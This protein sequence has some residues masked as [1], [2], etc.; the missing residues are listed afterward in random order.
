MTRRCGQARW[1]GTLACGL[2]TLVWLGNMSGCSPI[3][4]VTSVVSPV[5]AAKRQI[6]PATDDSIPLRATWS[7]HG[8]DRSIT[9]SL[10]WQDACVVRA[11]QATETTVVTTTKPNV[12]GDVA[13]LVAGL[14]LIGGG[15]TTA[16]LVAPSVGKGGDETAGAVGGA[17]I[18]AGIFGLVATYYSIAELAKESTTTRTSTGTGSHETLGTAKVSCGRKDALAGMELALEAQG[19][20]ALSAR[21][22]RLGHARFELPED[23]EVD[24][25]A[26]A[27][28]TIASSPDGLASLL[29]AGTVLGEVSLSEYAS[30]IAA[31]RA[32]SDSRLRSAIREA[33]AQDFEGVI[34]GD[35]TAKQGFSLA[36]T[37]G[38]K[39]V[40]FD[41]IDNDC[42]GLYDVGC[43]YESGALQWTLAWKTGDDLDLH[44]VGPDNVEVFYAHRKGGSSGLMLDIDC[45]GQFG[46]NCLASNVENIFTPRDKKPKEGTY[47]G[48]VEVF[49]AAS[50]DSDPGRVISAML[51]G[52]IAG[53]TFRMPMTLAAQRH[54]RVSFAFAVGKDRDKDSV[55]DRE[56]ACPGEAGVFSSYPAEN[57][58]PDRDMDGVADKLDA[59]PDEVGLR[60]RAAKDNGCPRK[61]GKAWLTDR[62]VHITEAIHF[63]S[64]SAVISAQSY[65]LLKDIGDVMRA[66]PELLQEVNIEGHTDSDGEPPKNRKLSFERVKSV[67]QHLI[68]REKIPPSRLG[69]AWFGPDRPV[70]SND[71]ERGKAQNRRVEFRVVKPAP[72]AV[73]SW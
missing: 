49:R 33:D 6:V 38:G 42:D 54:V 57:G 8:G 59:C 73:L 46:S 34:H 35:D 16:V 63:A 30:A 70:A 19:G 21:V 15:A 36:C 47:R 65:P 22:D 58:C 5:G 26:K 39:D 61:F 60:T 40:C 1:L 66:A 51:G 67:F 50:D 32:A 24:P 10:D 2:S 72:R 29:K 43:G 45:L 55:I 3:V 27:T 37:P 52:R 64:G 7:F 62:G 56:D 11:E 23:A 9:G 44:V 25:S 53:K 68:K 14:A 20:I 41:A 71:T 18:V 31:R 28:I 12:A 48:W 4:E 13:G 17:G 69:F